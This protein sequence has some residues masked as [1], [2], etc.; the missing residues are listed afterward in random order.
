MLLELPLEI[1]REILTLVLV[2]KSRINT[3]EPVRATAK[4]DRGRYKIISSKK[5]TRVITRKDLA[6]LSVSRAVRD[7][8][9]DIFWG[10]NTFYLY[11][12]TP[13]SSWRSTR[14]LDFQ[15]PST[16]KLVRKIEVE[17]S[18]EDSRPSAWPLLFCD[19]IAYMGNI[20]G[21]DTT[22][23]LTIEIR[24]DT[25]W[26]GIR[27]YLCPHVEEVVW[28]AFMRRAKSRFPNLDFN[29]IKMDMVVG[30]VEC[31]PRAPPAEEIPGHVFTCIHNPY[32]TSLINEGL[33]KI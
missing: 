9:L 22:G 17:L 33:D 10:M 24:V 15:K 6:L 2:D 5:P 23:R 3:F 30:R 18:S 25:K 12:A 28:T 7:V 16:R 26:N 27:V 13:Y 14:F 4:L 20:K 32:I 11:S 1:L 31:F 8:S 21:L 29:Y 19:Q